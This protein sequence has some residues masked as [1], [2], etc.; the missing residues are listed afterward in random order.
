MS[1][2]SCRGWGDIVTALASIISVI[3]TVMSSSQTLKS[4]P[5]L[6]SCHHSSMLPSF[7]KKYL[8]WYLQFTLDMSV[9]LSFP[10]Y[11][12]RINWISS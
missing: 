7:D 1:D 11:R 12:V 2:V 8:V 5:Y 3:T 4:A 6:V 9:H 10:H